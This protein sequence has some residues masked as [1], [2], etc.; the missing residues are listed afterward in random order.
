MGKQYQTRDAEASRWGFA[1]ARGWHQGYPKKLG[2]IWMTRPAAYGRAGRAWSP[3][4]D[5]APRWPPW[6]AA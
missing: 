5:S 4:A 1:L 3:A 6:T 2:S